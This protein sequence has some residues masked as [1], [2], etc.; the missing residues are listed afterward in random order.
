MATPRPPLVASALLVMLACAPEASASSVDLFGYGARGIAMSGAALSSTGGQAAVYYNPA[1][2]ALESRPSFALGI[3][4]ATFH[5]RQNGRDVGARRAPAL[6]LGL[7]MPLPLRGWL[8]RRIALGMGLIIPQ[9]SILIADLHRPGDTDFVVLANRAQTVSIQTAIAFRPID[10]L[11][12]GIGVLTLA[13]LEGG[14]EVAPREGGRLGS[15]VRD[16]VIASYSLVV[17]MQ[18]SPTDWLSLALTWRAE[19]RADFDFPVQ[20]DLGDTV[21]LPVPTLDIRGTAQFDPAQLA[22]ELALRPRPWLLVAFDVASKRWS[23][24][25]NPIVYTAVPEDYPPQ[26]VPAFHDIVVW[27]VGAEATADI[28]EWRLLPRLGF[29]WEPSPAPAQTGLHNYLDNDRAILGAGVGVRWRRL[30]L[31]VAGQVQLLRARTEV[32]DPALVDDTASNPGW[33][34]IRHDGEVV[35]WSVE[36]GAEL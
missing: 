26:P 23:R 27:R 14:V 3:Q 36:L 15:S 4:E 35:I 17:G 28:G 8:D 18:A 19:S 9:N 1:G 21:P 6:M 12:L 11:S 7:A 30:R 29:A 13:G 31:D 32:K 20:A 5:L 25:D 2:L 33:P 22:M 24:F 34:S 16:V 10:R